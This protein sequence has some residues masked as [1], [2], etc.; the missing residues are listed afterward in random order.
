MYL[1]FFK[2]CR[3]EKLIPNNINLSFLMKN[4]HIENILKKTYFALLIEYRIYEKLNL[5]FNLNT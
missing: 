1:D 5:L 2:I 3:D 4:H